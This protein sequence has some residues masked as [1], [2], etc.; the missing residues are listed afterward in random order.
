MKPNECVANSAAIQY[1][2]THEPVQADLLVWATWRSLY[3]KGTTLSQ[4]MSSEPGWQLNLTPVHYTQD[5][6]RQSP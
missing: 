3:E 2:H 6:N 4:A 5:L 1:A